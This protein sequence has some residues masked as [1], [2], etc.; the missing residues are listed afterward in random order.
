M[1]TS[2]WHFFDLESRSGV[3]ILILS[4]FPPGISSKN[5][6]TGYFLSKSHCLGRPC[7]QAVAENRTHNENS[8]DKIGLVSTIACLKV[9][10]MA[11]DNVVRIWRRLGMENFRSYLRESGRGDPSLGSTLESRERLQHFTFP[12]ARSAVP[13]AMQC[14][15]KLAL[16]L[17]RHENR[18][19]SK[20]VEF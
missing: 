16:A 5:K 19:H 11:A 14:N 9:S 10:R 8:H 3:R 12:L 2:S 15:Q 20:C 18:L 6:A 4:T 13:S 7:R 1:T 17:G